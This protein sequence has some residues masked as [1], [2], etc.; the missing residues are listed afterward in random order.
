[1][2]IE[3]DFIG[4]VEIP[5]DALYG[6]HAVRARENFPNEIPFHP[7]WYQALG[8]TKLAVYQVYRNFKAAVSHKFP[9]KADRLKLMDENIIEALI[10]AS[11]LVSEGMHFDQFIVPAFQG[12][13]GTSINMNLNEIIA[14][15]SLKHLGRNP[16]DYDAIH[17]VENAN[18]FQSTNDVIPTSLRIA[19]MRL[20]ITLE[21]KINSLRFEVEK[22]EKEHRDSLRI[23]YTQMQEAVPSSYGR[24][25]S[26]YNDA[27]SRDWWRV[28]K[29]AER[30]KVVNLG[31]T[32]IGSGISV[33]RYYI[34]EVV[35]KLQEITKLPVTRGENLQDA[36]ANLDPFV[37]V[38]AILKAHAVN[39]EKMVN[40]IRLLSSDIAGNRELEIPKKQVGSSIMPS[41]VNPVIPEYIVSIAHQVYSN[42]LLITSLS[43]QGCLDL[44]AYIPVIGHALIQSIKL[45]ISA[46]QSLQ[47]QLFTGLKVNSSIS[48]ER[49]FKSPVITTILIPFIGYKKATELSD[50]MIQEK[51]SVFEANRKLKLMEEEKLTSFLTTSNLLKAG[52]SVED[53]L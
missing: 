16:G 11:S 4:E 36:T 27:L 12:G 40:D 38:H 52:Y 18:I 28:S 15:L 33:P 34:L 6:I 31:G 46:N 49:L 43:A 9:G 51:C 24:L 10:Y 14:N 44:N 7:E 1:M 53:I 17:P 45:L 47:V 35:R 50:T 2:R 41:K 19:V 30:I 48:S 25:F 37:E 32:A 21:E 42:D 3:K 29:C 8:I 13:A 5:E 39:L 20:L 26:T 22:L 23:A